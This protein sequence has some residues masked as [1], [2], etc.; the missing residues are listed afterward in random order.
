MKTSPSWGNFTK[1]AQSSTA[2]SVLSEFC[3]HMGENLS[4]VM[5]EQCPGPEF[6]YRFIVGKGQSPRF[7]VCVGK[8]LE[9]LYLSAFTLLDKVCCPFFLEKYDCF[10]LL[11]FF[12]PLC[13]LAFF[14]SFLCSSSTFLSS[15]ISFPDLC[16]ISPAL[17]LPSSC[18]WES[19]FYVIDQAHCFIGGNRIL[20]IY[21]RR[22]CYD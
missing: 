9:I 17:V 19:A 1:T 6:S 5:P 12:F 8:A 15:V 13:L 14:P 22:C 18:D 4:T 7:N 21:I 20:A 11:P 3:K 10:F 2:I 16:L